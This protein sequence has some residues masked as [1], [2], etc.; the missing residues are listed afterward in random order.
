MQRRTALARRSERIAETTLAFPHHLFG[1]LRYII[2]LT[3]FLSPRVVAL[4]SWGPCKASLAWKTQSLVQDA[5][6][7]L[8]PSLEQ[9]LLSVTGVNKSFRFQLLRLG[10][11][12]SEGIET[13]DNQAAFLV[14]IAPPE[15]PAASRFAISYACDWQCGLAVSVI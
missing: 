10:G 13:L 7:C 15:E 4:D 9:E 11:N 3:V 2:L 1:G 12:P 14:V 5:N 8:I 6:R